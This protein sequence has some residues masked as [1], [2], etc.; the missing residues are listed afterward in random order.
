MP[1]LLDLVELEVKRAADELRVSR[2]RDTDCERERA[3]GVE[4]EKGD[5]EKGVDELMEAGGQLHTAA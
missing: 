1:E 4:R 2:R 5:G 3:A